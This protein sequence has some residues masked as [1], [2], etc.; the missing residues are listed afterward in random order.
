MKR[1]RPEVGEAQRTVGDRQVKCYT[2]I[3]LGAGMVLEGMIPREA[4]LW[5]T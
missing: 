3:G 5:E 1:A 4:I 2:G